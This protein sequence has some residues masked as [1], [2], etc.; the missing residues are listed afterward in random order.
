MMNLRLLSFLMLIALAFSA[1]NKENSALVKRKYNKGYYYSHQNKHNEIRVPNSVESIVK[2]ELSKTNTEINFS[3]DASSSIISL[4]DNKDTLKTESQRPTEK[5]EEED[6][7]IRETPNTNPP[8]ETYQA[9]PE[10][11]PVQ[12]R[13]TNIM[14]VISFNLVCLFLVSIS[15]VPVI[16]FLSIVGAF[17]FGLIALRQ[18]RKE[19]GKYKGAWYAIVGVAFPA[20]LASIYL[21]A[22]FYVIFY[23]LSFF[24]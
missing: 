15:W 10:N 20:L 5:K 24:I 17:I 7:Y 11:A 12:E 13:K 4:S 14:G 6:F 19:K 8:V 2:N 1:C 23:Y 3:A 16:A 22:L 9:P 18:F 21:F